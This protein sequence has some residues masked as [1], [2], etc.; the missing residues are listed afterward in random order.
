ME[1]TLTFPL[2]NIK[3][4]YKYQASNHLDNAID[5][6]GEKGRSC[7]RKAKVSENG[8]SVVI[9]GT[10]LDEHMLVLIDINEGKR[11]NEK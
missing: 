6:L 5:A 8:G 4:K 2:S 11:G 3:E 9:D 10:S 7:T 1:I